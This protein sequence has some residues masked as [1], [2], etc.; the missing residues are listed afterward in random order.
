MDEHTL[1]NVD[2]NLNKQ[3][4]QRAE[5]EAFDYNG[6]ELVAFISKV[7]VSKSVRVRACCRPE[8]LTLE[9]PPLGIEPVI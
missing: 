2:Y 4:I 5:A 3:S 8:G 6:A 1:E 9:T 7:L